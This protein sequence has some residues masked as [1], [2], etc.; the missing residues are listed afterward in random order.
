[1]RD[2]AHAALNNLDKDLA[3]LVQEQASMR[4]AAKDLPQNAQPD[5]SAGERP[6]R[7]LEKGRK[8]LHDFVDALDEIIKKTE[9]PK[10]KEMQT[11][12]EEAK[13]AEDNADFGKALAL[14]EEVLA[15]GFKEAKL[16][17]HV[18]ELKAAWEV[19]DDKL[20][21][22]RT[23]IYE[24]WPKINLVKGKE[25]LKEARKAFELCKAG[26]DRL[27]P[28][29]LLKVAETHI[30]ELQKATAELKPDINEDDK[31]AS[32]AIIK[33]TDELTKLIQ[34]VAAYL[35]SPKS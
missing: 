33:V 1:V 28:L 2:R 17:D 34:D 7:E 21:Q 15:A 30:A 20:R 31:R 14:Y 5:L 29:K 13:I 25:P 35:Q 9:D 23:Y 26:N 22:A 32:E 8:K 6:L 3:L 16:V 27:G 4:E 24:N 12:V 19:K 11:K 18:A 10:I